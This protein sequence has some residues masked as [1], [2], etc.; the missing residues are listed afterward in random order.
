MLPYTWAV[1]LGKIP[2]PPAGGGGFATLGI[3]GYPRDKTWNTSK[4]LE[5]NSR[6]TPPILEKIVHAQFS[7]NT[8][9][10]LVQVSRKFV[11]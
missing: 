2:V 1:G 8:T 7:F 9:L 6:I 3:G 10:Q 11:Q 4:I 5:D